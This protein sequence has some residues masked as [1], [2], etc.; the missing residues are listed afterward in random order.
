ME[1]VLVLL[2]I[3]FLVF[4]DDSETVQMALAAFSSKNIIK[5]RK[6]NNVWN[7]FILKVNNKIF[8]KK[9]FVKT[10]NK[11]WN[12]IEKE[13]THDNH[14]FILFKIKYNNGEFVT[15]G[16]L[17]RLN[18]N[19][20]NS[21]INWI[22]NNMEFKSEYYNET[23][24]DSIII[25]YGFKKGI[26]ADKKTFQTNLPIQNYKNNNLIISYNPLDYGKLITT[27]ELR[28]ETLYIL[29]N[30]DHL[31]IK[32]L[33][34][35]NKNSI[36]IFNRADL[37]I[38]FTDFKI[39]EN[40]FLRILDNKKF[41]FENNQQILFTKEN[42]SKSIS[43]LEKS[44]NLINNFITLDIET[45]VQNNKLVP[46]CIS[47][48][49][50]KT[51]KS[52]F[53][54]DFQNS[55]QMILTALKSIL[56]RKYNGY[57]VYMHNMAKFDIIFLLKHLIKLSSVQ[58]IIHNGRIISIY[59]NF[60]KDLKY[61][62]QFKDSY[63]ILISSLVKLTKGF[64]VDMIKSIFPF[65]FV[66]ENNLDYIGNV[67]EIKYFGN[68]IELT[69][70]N[71]Y[72]SKFN[73]NWNLKNETI[74]Y[75]EID[76][77]SLY[78]VIFKFSDL[79]F[80]MFNKN[81]HRYP[82]L[83]SLA[84]AIF[85]SCFMEKN[86]VPQVTGKIEKDIRSGY[87]GGAVDMYIPENPD[88]TK[89]YV[90]DANSLYPY[91]MQ[92]QP[93]PV[94][95][96][97]YF[98]GDI[99]KIDPNAFGF[100]YCKIIAPDD[101]KHP[102]LQTHIKTK[103]GL[104]TIAP[105]GTWEDMLFSQEMYNAK[106]YGYQFEILWGYTF[107]KKNIFK[108]YV[109]FLYNLRL[110]YDKSNPLNY[111]AKILLNSLYG[112]FGMNDNFP[113]IDI[114][115]KDYINDFE[116]KFLGQIIS[117]IKLDD[118]FLVIYESENVFKSY[119]T[120]NISIS[121]A[122]AI[123]AYARIHMSQFKNNP[124]INLFYSDTD[125]IYTDTDIDKSL[126]DSKILGK[127]KLENICKRAIFLAAKLYYLE[128]ESGKNIVKVKGLKDTSSLNYNDFKNLLN[129]NFIVKKSHTKWIR[130]LSESKINI[131]A[132][133]YSIKVT[134]NKRLLI[135]DNNNKLISTENYKI[136]KNKNI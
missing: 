60:G 85:R 116:N 59:L 127:L 81:I 132:Q 19:D 67:P 33:K 102:I 5:L 69:D 104:R 2:V 25:T 78:Q 24:I 42:K 110:K 13:F 77:I 90:Y 92:S 123:T 61:S 101:I 28:D 117:K 35:E 29:Q 50:G 38:K 16:N 8:S 58:P 97:T 105:I 40:K 18:Q 136:D 62:I 20:K 44:K 54:T 89:V 6:T 45:F 7:E 56:I 79:I 36:E 70:Y 14:L 41:Y 82:T 55:E 86:S 32:I 114:I 124:K 95:N 74:K 93:M 122:V 80:S 119:E 88:A 121:I 109:D 135:Y 15:I 72:K 17:Q 65:L 71:E 37:I 46:F 64:R 96:P 106:K 98:E 108:D 115:H 120:H 10:F 27:I 39:G 4:T 112:R 9:L 103:N 131:I 134:D 57:N 111:I 11:F 87:T 52:F 66:N 100:F 48:Y 22:I 133:I 34:S 21:Y 3:L 76:C 63:L 99:R 84:F 75:C 51:A 128:T 30:E 26:I 125:S 129:K 68:K 91:I 107:E 23:Q 94:G 31:I 53:Y 73:K 126:I 43:I 49:D 130:N 118:H 1:V 83:P 47:I 113:E 12:E